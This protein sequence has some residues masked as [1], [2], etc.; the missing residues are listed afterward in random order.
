L[1]VFRLD[2]YETLHIE[3]SCFHRKGLEIGIGFI[4]NI[5]NFKLFNLE[6]FVYG[7]NDWDYIFQNFSLKDL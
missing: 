3:I 2:N 6:L 5:E 1:I 7:S 4:G